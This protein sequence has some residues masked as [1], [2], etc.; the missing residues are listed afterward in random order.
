M[1]YFAYGSNMSVSRLRER[2]PSAEALGCWA[3]REHDLRFHKCSSDGSAKCDA[4]FTSDVDD[5]IYGVLFKIDAVGKHALDKAEGLGCGYDEK[6]V[7]LTAQDGASINA[8]TYV[9]TNID[10]NMKPYSWYV[11]HVPLGARLALLPADYIELKITSVEA[12]GDGDKDRDAS[13]RA[14]HR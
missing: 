3:L 6:E 12:V 14:I 7:R 4:Y 11:N 2:V 5:V 1:H 13:E 8:T 9:A 10:E